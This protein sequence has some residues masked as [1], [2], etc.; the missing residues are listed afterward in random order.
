[1]TVIAQHSNTDIA[2]IMYTHTPVRTTTQ[3]TME[4]DPVTTKDWQCGYHV[5]EAEQIVLLNSN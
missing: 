5:M 2:L 1:M 3:T 4:G